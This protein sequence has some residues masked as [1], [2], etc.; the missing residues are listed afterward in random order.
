M[1]PCAHHRPYSKHS[2]ERRQQRDEQDL[3]K[4]QRHAKRWR[5]AVCTDPAL[6]SQREEREEKRRKTQD[7]RIQHAW[8]VDGHFERM[9]SPLA[10]HFAAST[11]ATFTFE[12][13]STTAS[14]SMADVIDLDAH[15]CT[16][17]DTPNSCAT[18]AEW[19]P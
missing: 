7:E 18:T 10:K 16:P 13:P 1:A 6:P 3:I 15:E 17:P 9:Q 19:D 8:A 14:S 11:K 5:S 2:R 12:E 4:R